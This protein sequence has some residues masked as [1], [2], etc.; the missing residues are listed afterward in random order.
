MFLAIKFNS[1]TVFSSGKF[2]QLTDLLTSKN[3]CIKNFYLAKAHKTVWNSREKFFVTKQMPAELDLLATMAQSPAKYRWEIPI[4]HVVST[5]FDYTVTGNA[6]LTGCG[7]FCPELK[8]WY[9][10]H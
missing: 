4:R 2:R 8:F 7:A 6:C 9:Y 3:I 5:A 1:N 10:A